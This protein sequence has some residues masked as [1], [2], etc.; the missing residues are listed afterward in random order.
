MPVKKS[1]AN[2]Q[3]SFLPGGKA[4]VNFGFNAAHRG[5]PAPQERVG[6]H[7]RE[8][9]GPLG[10]LVPLAPSGRPHR[11]RP[12]PQARRGHAAARPL[13][14]P[15]PR[16]GE[17]GGSPRSGRAFGEAAGVGG[18]GRSG[19]VFLLPSLPPAHPAG[20]ASLVAARVRSR[21]LGNAALLSP[22]GRCRG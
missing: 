20:R 17:A 9:A 19:A 3:L 10:R 8:A 4:H 12:P 18:A 15:A 21:L 16:C 11:A 1:I 22:S 14:G 5:S 6:Q 7:R 2:Q 13:G